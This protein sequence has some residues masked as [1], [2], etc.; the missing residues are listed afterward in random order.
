MTGFLK[1]S[2]AVE[3]SDGRN[4]TLLEPLSFVAKS[5]RA[6]VVPVGSTTDGASTPGILWAQMPPFGKYW[7]AAVL[8]DWAYRYSD[9]T[10]DDCDSLLLEAMRDLDVEQLEADAIYEG[11]RLGGQQSFDEDRA[12]RSKGGNI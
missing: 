7:L 8:H 12:A 9:L 2:L 1:T 10:K 6:F 5:G 3:T 11:V 4:F